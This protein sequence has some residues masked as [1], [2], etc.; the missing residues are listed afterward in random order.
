MKKVSILIF[1]LIIISNILLTQSAFA[2]ENAEYG[3]SVTPPESWKI[4]EDEDEEMFIAIW[5]HPDIPA[6]ILIVV[7]EIQDWTLS[8]YIENGKTDLA[9][10]ENYT[11][12]SEGPRTIG[13]LNGY[14]IDFTFNQDEYF[15]KTSKIAFTENNKGYSITIQA[16]VSDFPDT[17]LKVEE[18]INSFK[19]TPISQN[20]TITSFQDYT[21]I[22]VITG[23]GI[24]ALV[25]YALYSVHN[26][27]QKLNNPTV[28]ASSASNQVVNQNEINV[29]FC[30]YCGMDN[31]KDA[32]F[33]EKCGK[34]IE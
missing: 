25:G 4:F 9:K 3:F 24:V 8:Q 26:R 23:I 29:K 5:Q 21:L 15:I 14:Q 2:Y 18:S 32:V 6:G 19:I 20:D 31:K 22:G 7:E 17:L 33:C 30:R 12:V 11:L 13:E 27:K 28:T 1:V 34:N 16:L 10:L